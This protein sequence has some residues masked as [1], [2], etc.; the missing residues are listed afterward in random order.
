MN[1]PAVFILF[2]LSLLLTK[3][4]KGSAAI[5]SFIVVI[6][7][8]IVI[9][10]IILGWQFIN[11]DNLHPFTIPADAG[12]VKLSDGRIHDY[13]ETL[14]HGWAGVLRGAAVVFFAFIGFDAVSTAAQE[15][16]KPQATSN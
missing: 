15:A 2:L 5:N 14:N 7:V 6:K 13:S 12:T 4:T 10:F 3:G 9:M 8:A 1:I 11:P 16:K